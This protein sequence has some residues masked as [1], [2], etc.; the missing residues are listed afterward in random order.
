MKRVVE[1]AQII[2]MAQTMVYAVLLGWLDVNE[3]EIVGASGT[4]V[5]SHLKRV[6]ELRADYEYTSGYH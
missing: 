5:T 6:V 1:F 4:K 2:N 3:S